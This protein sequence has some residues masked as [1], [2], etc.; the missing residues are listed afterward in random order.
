MKGYLQQLLQL[1][2]SVIAQSTSAIYKGVLSFLF[3]CIIIWDLPQLER[4]VKSLSESRLGLV[5]RTIAPR[6]QRETASSGL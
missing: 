3:S 1:A 6:L 4:A 5:Y 2:S